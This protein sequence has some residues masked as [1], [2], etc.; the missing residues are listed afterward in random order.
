MLEIGTGLRYGAAI[1]GRIA[2]AVYTVERHAS[3]AEPAR[4][5]LEKLGYDNVQVLLGDGSLGW[6]EYAIAPIDTPFFSI[7]L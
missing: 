5:R 6:P 7:I 3:L 2:R 1:L 4:E